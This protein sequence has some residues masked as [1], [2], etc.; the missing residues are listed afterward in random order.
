MSIDLMQWLL[1]GTES[2]VRTICCWIDCVLTY[3]IYLSNSIFRSL[4][5][6]FAAIELS[7][8]ICFI[9]CLDWCYVA[10]YVCRPEANIGSFC[11][12]Q[13]FIDIW[14]I[15]AKHVPV[16]TVPSAGLVYLFCSMFQLMSSKFGFTFRM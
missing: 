12:N 16:N 3:W 7:D 13:S 6:W 4:P 1:C 15:L 11:I 2:V 5:L 8:L 10:S 9:A 14:C